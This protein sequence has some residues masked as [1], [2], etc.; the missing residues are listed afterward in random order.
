GTREQARDLFAGTPTQGLVVDG[1]EFAAVDD[2][3][4]RDDDGRQRVSGRAVDEARV[5]VDVRR[6]E[7]PGTREIPDAEVRGLAWFEASDASVH[8][9]R[10]RALDRREL[11]RI[12]GREL[13]RPLAVLLQQGTQAHLLEDVEVVVARRAVTADPEGARRYAAEEPEVRD[14]GAE[15][16]VR[17][18][19]M[20]DPERT[21]REHVD[22]FGP[23]VHGVRAAKGEGQ[24]AESIEVIELAHP[25]RTA[26]LRALLRMFEQM[27]VD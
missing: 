17:R 15:L 10:P 22:G 8:P 1:D 24:H 19:A 5:G 21:S 18:G 3:L 7:A 9:E 23:Q 20:A 26:D 13:A 16:E 11:D 14:A 4:A 2:D 25:E 27:R 6:T 12:A